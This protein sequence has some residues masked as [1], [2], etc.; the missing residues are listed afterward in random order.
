MENHIKCALI[1]EPPIDKTTRSFSR[2]FAVNLAASIKAEGLFHPIVVRPHPDRPGRYLLVQG[3]HR[4]Y[5]VKKVL[6]EPEIRATILEG[7]DDVGHKM[8][9]ISENLWRLR[10]SGPE[11]VA[12][13]KKWRERF[14]QQQPAETAI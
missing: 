4:L 2:E 3:R 5:A 7:L 11:R 12:A 14:L 10:S 6:K 13:V 8:A 9:S 1:D